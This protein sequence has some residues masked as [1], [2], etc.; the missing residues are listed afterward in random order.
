MSRVNFMLDA[1]DRCPVKYMEFTR[2]YSKFPDAMICLF[3]GEDV[4]YYGF[5]V[6]F[7]LKGYKW[8]PIECNGKKDVLELYR[9]ISNHEEYSKANALFFIDR[10]FDEPIENIHR[11]YIYETPCYSIENFYA[12]KDC[13]RSILV[14]EFKISEFCANSQ[15]HLNCLE[16]FE[17]VQSL[18]H[19]AIFFLN[20]WIKAH[21]KKER[22]NKI[23]RLNLNN[24]NIDKIVLISLENI[25]KQYSDD[26]LNILFPEASTIDQQEIQ[27]ALDSFSGKNLTYEFRGKY[28]A[29]FVRLFLIKLRED[30]RKNTPKIFS[31]RG[32]VKLNISRKNIISELSQYADTPDCL[33]IFLTEKFDLIR[34]NGSIH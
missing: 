20:A 30:R 18:F 9:V 24:V 8:I 31:K 13:F 17:K 34:K 33:E 4:K 10:D 3:E 25:E 19:N 23:N 14:S 21:R 32:S 27:S 16:A 6:E 28:E 12:S 7:Y 2:V 1:L 5:R 11:K 22:E 29:E 15:C 26:K